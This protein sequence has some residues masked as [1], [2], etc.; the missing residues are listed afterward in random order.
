MPIISKAQFSNSEPFMDTP[1]DQVI[2]EDAVTQSVPLTGI[3]DNDGG[4]QVI[5]IT[6]ISS[7]QSII[8]DANISISYTNPQTTGTLQ[9]TVSPDANGLVSITINVKDDGGVANGG[10]DTYVTNFSVTVNPVNDKPTFTKGPDLPVSPDLILEDAGTF[11]LSNWATN[12]NEGG[13]LGN[14]GFQDLSFSLTPI[15]S[16]GNLAF[17]DISISSVGVVS[18]TPSTN[19][20][21]TAEYQVVLEDDGSGTPPDENTSDPETFTI[22]VTSVN[23]PPVFTAGPDIS[24]DEGD[25]AQLFNSWATGI[26]PGGGS[27]ESGQSLTFNVVEQSSSTFLTFL[28]APAID[29]TTGNLTFEADPD[30][31]GTATFEVTLSDDGGS[32]SPDINV[33]TAVTFTITINSI[34]DP[35]TATIPTT[36][37][38]FEDAGEVSVPGFVTGISAGAADEETTQTVSF[39][40]DVVSTTGT[41]AFDVLPEINDIGTFTFTTSANTNGTAEIQV[42]VFDDGSN[43][44]PNSNVGPVTNVTI[45]VAAVNDRPTF[46]KGADPTLLED[47]G[48]TAFS[49]WALNISPGPSDESGQSVSFQVTQVWTEGNIAFTSGPDLSPSGDLSFETAPNTNGRAAYEI[50][51][52]D[53]G[54][55]DGLN[56]NTSA[57]QSLVFEIGAVNDPPV[58]TIGP[59]QVVDENST[60]VT[61]TGWAT[62]MNPG[63]GDDE[64]SQSYSFV[65]ETFEITGSL[66]FSIGP[67][68]SPEGDLS[69]QSAPNTFGTATF[70]LNLVDDGPSEAPNN[71][72]SDNQSFMITINEINDPPTDIILS[73]NNIQEKLPVSTVVGTITALDPDNTSHTFSLVNGTGGEDNGSFQIDGDRLLSNA[74][75][76][77]AEKNLYTIRVSASDGE[78]EI[79]RIF[80]IDILREPVTS[81]D[82]PNAF[83]PNGDG[84]N[85]TWEIQSIEYFPGAIITIYN[86]NGQKVFD[87]VGYQE[88]WD[89][90]YN[91][92]NLPIDTYFV[93]IKLNDE[94]ETVNA[95]VTILR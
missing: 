26:G 11:T 67:L 6:A 79:E 19:T 43:V 86:R 40:I 29:A 87:S 69:F 91:G 3:T 45:T 20:N 23:D 53:D 14:E 44:S 28:S 95:T 70:L 83:T 4:T 47:N 93:V 2:L 12:I 80:L 59:N 74:T 73:N 63:G 7:N 42:S 35:P 5:T 32:T 90:T 36:Y 37:D 68:V 78:N 65:V 84:E 88:P 31:T 1:S 22:T 92:S 77:F 24:L 16:T 21:G 57:I 66:V 49:P 39:D 27:D 9:Y 94:L 17:D 81:V 61:V 72:T 82:F 62:G 64:A 58:F 30:A 56:L 48:P 15:S 8:P 34:N 89:G 71:N 54:P 52:V 75:F 51:L 46:T 85:D 13:T 41:L 25:G 60:L 55:S 18:F 76:D 10:D 50:V 38:T 33:S